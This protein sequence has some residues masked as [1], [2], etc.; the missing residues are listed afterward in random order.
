MLS[1]VLGEAGPLPGALLED[2]ALVTFEG[3]FNK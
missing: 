1:S 3:P 2:G